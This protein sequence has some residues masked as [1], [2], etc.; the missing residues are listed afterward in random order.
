MRGVDEEDKIKEREWR[1]KLK[2]EGGRKMRRKG[3]NVEYEG[4]ERNRSKGSQ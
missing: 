4:G 1:L 3:V 2:A